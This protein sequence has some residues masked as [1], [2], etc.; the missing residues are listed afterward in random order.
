MPICIVCLAIFALVLDRGGNSTPQLLQSIY[1]FDLERLARALDVT[2]I[3]GSLPA[4]WWGAFHHLS[5]TVTMREGLSSAQ[6]RSVLAHEL[7]HAQQ[8]ARGFALPTSKQERAAD[9]FAAKH[10]I[11]MDDYHEALARHGLNIAAMADDLDVMPWVVREYADT[12]SGSLYRR[13]GLPAVSAI[14][15]EQYTSC[16][17]TDITELVG[18]VPTIV[19]NNVL[20]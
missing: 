4:G 2:V 20:L 6:F 13:I 18:F 12:I 8:G 5:R 1:L 15:E 10:L 7:G 16:T 9:R 14:P 11:R 19:G 17:V 3:F